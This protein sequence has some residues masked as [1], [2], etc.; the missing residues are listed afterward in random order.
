LILTGMTLDPS[1]KLNGIGGKALEAAR[2]GFS[3][4]QQTPKPQ[5]AAQ[6]L[7]IVVFRSPA[8][9]GG[10]KILEQAHGD[11]LRCIHTRDIVF[12]PKDL[13]ISF[14]KVHSPSRDDPRNFKPFTLA[15]EVLKTGASAQ[16]E[17]TIDRQLL[18]GQWAE[19]L[20]F[21]GRAFTWENLSQWSCIH[22]V[23]FLTKEKQR[24]ERNGL[25][26]LPE[27]LG[28]LQ[29]RFQ[30]AQ[31]QGAIA[32]QLGWGIGWEGTTGGLADA[33]YRKDLLRSFRNMTKLDPGVYS[34]KM[35]FPK[36]RKLIERGGYGVLGWILLEP[37]SVS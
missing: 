32:L 5:W 29:S 8:G 37:L 15:T 9:M 24:A 4:S 12:S 17:L 7:E 6:P 35:P 33:V 22:A 26:G 13:D 31:R 11:L 34:E 20:N 21:A 16:T 25:P 18:Q 2:R 30:A 36:S 10:P 27:E 23:R 28:K 1:G 3:S 19:K 14:I